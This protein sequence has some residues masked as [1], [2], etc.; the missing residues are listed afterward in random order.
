MA[1]RLYF[2]WGYLTWG[3]VDKP[4]WWVG[5]CIFFQLW[6]YL[7]QISLRLFFFGWQKGREKMI[8][9]W[10][11]VSRMNDVIVFCVYFDL[12]CCWRVYSMS[13]WIEFGGTVSLLRWNEW[14]Q[15]FYFVYISCTKMGWGFRLSE[16]DVFI[17]H[18]KEKCWYSSGPRFINGWNHH[19][20]SPHV[21]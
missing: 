15:L 12:F 5:T 9:L 8:D 1:L 14:R 19:L 16:S 11:K 18:P 7:C 4:W 10:L 6:R 3:Q 20:I 17:C 13:L 2:S 21:C